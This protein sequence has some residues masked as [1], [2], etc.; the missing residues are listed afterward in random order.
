M[1]QIGQLGQAAFDTAARN[2]LVILAILLTLH[3][4]F[5]RF[6]LKHRLGG[7]AWPIHVAA[8]TLALLVLALFT[9]D[10]VAPFIYFQF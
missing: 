4:V 3:W 5:G 1:G 2:G 6:D 8:T 9:P 10:T 7:A